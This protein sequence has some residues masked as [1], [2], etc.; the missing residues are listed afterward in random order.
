M[1]YLSQPE[2]T[3]LHWAEDDKTKSPSCAVLGAELGAGRTL[4]EDLQKRY[5]ESADGRAQRRGKVN[6]LD[7]GTML[8]F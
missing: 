8:G 4:Y 7:E 1:D 6:T 5:S 3:L 2:A